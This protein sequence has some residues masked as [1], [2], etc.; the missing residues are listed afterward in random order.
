MA[1]GT[2]DLTGVKY[3]QIG[4]RSYEIEGSA[5]DLDQIK[6]KAVEIDPS[7]VNADPVVSG[8]TITFARR[9]G[10]KGC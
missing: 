9:S 4:G 5:I 2:I 1:T 10:T 3:V 7:L 6:E 8:D